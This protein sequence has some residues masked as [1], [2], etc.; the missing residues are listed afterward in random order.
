MVILSTYKRGDLIKV[1]AKTNSAKEWIIVNGSLLEILKV[2]EDYL[3]KSL[4]TSKSTRIKFVNDFSF[5]IV[6]H[7]D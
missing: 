4:K 5:D 1:K 6:K 3:V 2:E 7:Y